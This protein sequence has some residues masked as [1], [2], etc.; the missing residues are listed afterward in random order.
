MIQVSRGGRCEV[1][2]GKTRWIV[3]IKMSVVAQ[4]IRKKRSRE[5]NHRAGGKEGRAVYLGRATRYHGLS[6]EAGSQIPF[7]SSKQDSLYFRNIKCAKTLT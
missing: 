2:V 7:F 1:F 6:G 4:R 3:M 5:I